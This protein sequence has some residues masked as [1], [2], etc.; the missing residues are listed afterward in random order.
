MAFLSVA[1]YRLWLLEDSRDIWYWHWNSP[2][3]KVL[4]FWFTL[5]NYRKLCFQG[6]CQIYHLC[7]AWCPTWILPCNSPALVSKL[8]KF[9]RLSC[10][11]RPDRNKLQMSSNAYRDQISLQSCLDSLQSF[12][13]IRKTICKGPASVTTHDSFKSVHWLNWPWVLKLVLIRWN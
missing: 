5:Q 6:D 12:V 1:I 10:F 2:W 7:W 4:Q 3:A 11:G 9:G 8:K 13:Y